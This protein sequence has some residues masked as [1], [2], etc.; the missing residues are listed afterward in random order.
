MNPTAN[1]SAGYYC[2]G[3]QDNPT[4]AGFECTQGHYCPS[5]SPSPQRCPSGNYQDDIGQ[6][7]CKGCPAGYYCDSTLSPVVL[8]N[9]SA[10]PE[11]FYCPENTTFAT[12]NPCLAGTFGNTTHR[13]DSSECQSC[14]GG[15]YCSQTGLD[16]PEGPCDAGYFCTSGSNSKTPSMGSNADIC[17]IGNYCPQGTTTPQECPPGTYNP[18]TGRQ[19]VDECL[20]C[21]GGRY[22]PDYGMTAVSAVTHK[23]SAGG[24]T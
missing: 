21:T 16:A 5:G 22:C 8:F 20:N 7:D 1:C 2:P 11:G 6:S 13:T 4:P 24:Y 19:S 18:S 15:M 14:T 9:N 10:C 3:G 17:T 23:C 12:E